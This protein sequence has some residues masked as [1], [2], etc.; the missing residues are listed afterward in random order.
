MKNTFSLCYREEIRK[1]ILQRAKEDKRIV[2]AAIIGSYAKGTVDRWSDIDLTF[3]VA[4]NYA[5]EE[6]LGNWT[7]YIKGEL[8]G[9]DLLD[10]YRGSTIYR[11][12]ILPGNL[13][14]DLSFSPEKEFGPLNKDFVL[15]YGKQFDKPQQP[16]Q[17]VDNLFGWIIHHLIRTKYCLERNR[18]WQAEYWLSEARDYM[19]KIAC[20]ER[21]L[22]PDRGRGFDDLPSEILT[23]AYDSY[24]REVRR[25]EI[26]LS[27]KRVVAAL[28][29]VLV[30]S[31]GLLKKYNN[32]LIEILVN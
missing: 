7:E 27:I 22:N 1:A 31:K 5:I 19:L 24:V 23:Y 10:T 26:L 11:V 28:P 30:S 6:V 21:G 13:Q 18:V 32:V 14:V 15:L 20:M 4:E 25:E 29:M 12:F 8:K 3:G 16:I 17:S 2:S 9:I